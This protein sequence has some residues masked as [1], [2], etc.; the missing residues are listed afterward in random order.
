MLEK[1]YSNENGDIGQ[2]NRLPPSFKMPKNVR[3]IGNNSSD[4]KIYV[5]DYVMTFIRQLAGDNYSNSKTAVLVGQYIRMDNA[6]MIF[7]SGAIELEGFDLST[8]D[9]FTNEV[10]TSIYENIKKYFVECEIVGWYLAGPSY[11]LKEQEKIR[12]IHV[13]NFAGRD[14]TLMTYDSMEREEAFWFYKDNKLAKQEGYYIYYDKNEDMQTYMI[15]HNNKGSQE[16]DYDDRVSKEIRAVLDNKKPEKKDKIEKIANVEGKGAPRLVYVAGTLLAVILLIAAAAMLDNYDQMKTMQDTLDSLASNYQLNYKEPAN[17]ENPLE[18][19]VLENAQARDD[20]EETVDPF[21]SGE[22][23]EVGG[24][25]LDVEILPGDVSPIEEDP[26]K[27]SDKPDKKV[28]DKPTSKPDKSPSEKEKKYYTV[29]AGD[30]LAGISYKLYD[31]PNYIS[32]IMRL[33]NMDDEN[34]IYIGQKLIVP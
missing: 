23:E 12:K 27:V 5:E 14:K 9:T 32:E 10:W 22:S 21:E 13:D 30:T 6:S 29:S 20:T 11:L 31:S 33:N 3:Q 24:E 25:N 28:T 4:K 26:V 7:I 15:D 8:G 34:Y 19:A 1:V 17:I 2:G 16:T 18:A